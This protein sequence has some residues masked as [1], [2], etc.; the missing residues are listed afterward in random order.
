MAA[1]APYALAAGHYLKRA[2][3]AAFDDFQPALSARPEEGQRL[4]YEFTVL[5]PRGALG[6]ALIGLAFGLTGSYFLSD[7]FFEFLQLASTPLSI[8]FNG[9]IGPMTWVV[10]AVLLYRILRMLF[11]VSYLFQHWTRVDLLYVDPLFA[12]SNLTAKAAVTILVLPALFVSAAPAIALQPV[13]AHLGL[14]YVVVGIATFGLPLTGIHRLLTAEKKRMLAE[15][16]ARM[17]KA[18]EDLH[19]RMDRRRL[20]RMDDLNKAMASLEIEHTTLVRIPTW[21]WEPATLR[22]FILA[23]VIPILIWLIQYILQKVLG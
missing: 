18:I 5:P 20:D 3:Q 7:R 9:V 6:A 17:R 8:V 16:A 14:G 2:A 12:L 23:L 22:G 19:E 11:L 13:S 21:P 10:F 4:R 15:H 1:A